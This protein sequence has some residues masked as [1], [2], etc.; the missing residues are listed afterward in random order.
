MLDQTLGPQADGTSWLDQ[1][2]GDDSDD[3]LVCGTSSDE[4]D[5]DA[6]EQMEGTMGEMDAE[7]ADD[8]KGGKVNSPP[9]CW[10]LW[11]CAVLRCSRCAVAEGV[12][13]VCRNWIQCSWT[14]KWSP[15]CSSRTRLSKGSRAP[16]PTSSDQWAYNY[17]T[18][19]TKKRK[20]NRL[21]PSD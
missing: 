14:W 9:R 19:S 6:D 10:F 17:L 20:R 12:C 21:P 13:R 18:I 16:S 8:L 1:L 2:S 15:I 7:I 4:D 5:I 3:E 11:G